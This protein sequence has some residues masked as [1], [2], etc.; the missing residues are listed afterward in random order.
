MHGQDGGK[1]N[2]LKHKKEVG[3][4]L[5]VYVGSQSDNDSLS[6]LVISLVCTEYCQISVLSIGDLVLIF[7]FFLFFWH[8]KMFSFSVLLSKVSVFGY[9]F[10]L[11]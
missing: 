1:K 3:N 11:L 4:N 8:T 10:G 6:S 7:T 9:G 5:Y 2:Q